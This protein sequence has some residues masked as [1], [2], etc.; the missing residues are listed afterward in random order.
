MKR[1]NTL[2]WGIAAFGWLLLVYLVVWHV[3]EITKIH[4]WANSG[5]RESLLT[6]I[7]DKPAVVVFR[8]VVSADFTT[9]PYP[10]SGDTVIAINDTSAPTRYA[11]LPPAWEPFPVGQPLPVTFVHNG[12]TLRTAFVMHA[13]SWALIWGFAVCEALRILVTLFSLGVGLWALRSQHGSNVVPIFALYSFSIAA[14]VSFIIS[15]LPGS[16]ATFSIPLVN[17]LF[18]IFCFFGFLYGGFWLHL[19]HVYPRPL[20]WVRRHAIWAYLL[21]YLPSLVIVLI[22]IDSILNIPLVTLQVHELTAWLVMAIIDPVPILI[23]IGILIYRYRSSTDAI[24]VRQ[25]RLILW[26][27]TGGIV[28][29]CAVFLVNTVF[30]DWYMARFHRDLVFSTVAFTALLLGPLAFAYAFRRYRL[31]EV[32]GRL[33]RATRD[34]LISGALILLLVGI[35]YGISQIMRGT[36]GVT[37]PTPSMALGFVLALGILPAQR[38]LRGLVERR[39]YPERQKLREMLHDFLQQASTLP[40][41]R[42]FWQELEEHLKEG[43][44]VAAVHPVLKNNL[45]S[46]FSNDSV[47]LFYLAQNQRPLLVDEAIGSGKMEI[48]DSEAAWLTERQVGL[49]LPMV[50]HQDLVGFLGI[51]LRTD[52]EDY[53]AEELHILNSLAPQIAIASENLKLLEENV[54]KRELEQQLQMARRIQQGF[55]PQQIP[56]T[57]GLEVAAVS[58]FCLD[59][60]GDYYDVVPLKTGCTVL[61]IGDVSGKG[62]GAALIMANLQASLRTTVRM[63]VPLAE[64]IA[65]INN[66]ICQNTPPEQYI[67]FFAASFNP[68]TSILTY[69]NAGHNAPMLIHMDGSC[70]LLEIGGMIMGTV[71]GLTYRQGTVQMVKDDL[72]L[73]YTDGASEAMNQAGEEFGEGRIEKL[74]IEHRNEDPREILRNLEQGVEAHHGSGTFEDDFTLLL[75]KFL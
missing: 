49:L 18:I 40:D 23:S 46:A 68:T 63:N 60:A 73:A 16:Y 3:R 26:A 38:R 71:P 42:L 72:L 14:N 51:G 21:C 69:V 48:R 29:G 57:P 22:W 65:E 47:L 41:Q 4:A 12:D 64:A 58:R 20:E 37:S 53:D 45:P 54:V 1:H 24:E 62:A 17:Q 74:L 36:L 10:V 7:S 39:L 19:Q 44:K 27:V 30:Y 34:A 31:M 55:L 8:S 75:A 25:L 2:R 67:T 15:F 5:F 6:Q 66:L 61:A 11:H 56:L 9:A 50:L 35:T 52:K 43:L 13:P 70:E 32:E 33:R 59:V 28:I